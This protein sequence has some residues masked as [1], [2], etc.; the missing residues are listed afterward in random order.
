MDWDRSDKEWEKWQQGTIKVKNFLLQYKTGLSKIK[1]ST[2]FC[3]D[4]ENSHSFTIS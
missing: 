4:C 2:N 1:I 3:L